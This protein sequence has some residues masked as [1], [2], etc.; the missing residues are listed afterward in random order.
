MKFDVVK[1]E[2]LMVFYYF[3]LF[4]LFF[5]SIFCAIKFVFDVVVLSGENKQRQYKIMEK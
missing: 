2:M 3:E 1:K 4:L 5:H